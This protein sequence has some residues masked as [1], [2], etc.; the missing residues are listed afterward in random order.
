LGVLDRRAGEQM[1]VTLI[2]LVTKFSGGATRRY[3]VTISRPLPRI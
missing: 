3:T 1:E 2:N